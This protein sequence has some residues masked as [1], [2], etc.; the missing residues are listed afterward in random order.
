VA[1][2]VADGAWYDHGPSIELRADDG[3]DG[4]GVAAVHY[5]IDDAAPVTVDDAAT[6]FVLAADARTH[7]DDGAHTVVYW[8]TDD[9]GNVEARQTVTV[10]IDTQAP[11]TRAP[12]S[13]SVRRGRVAVL[14]FRA[15]DAQ[16]SSGV[17]GV[18]IRIVDR[19]GRVVKTMAAAIKG[20]DGA[21]ALRFRCRLQAG[22]Y[23]FRVE[24]ADAAG[25]T[26]AA[27]AWNRL[28]VR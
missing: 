8:A 7:Q 17:D 5:A 25:N 18:T 20:S 19:R 2:G 13:A 11:A 10:N 12:R 9:A 27:P 15:F 21:G 22:V 24:A 16:P 6:T 3:P 28:R 23:R 14:R 26:Q 1:L 4:S